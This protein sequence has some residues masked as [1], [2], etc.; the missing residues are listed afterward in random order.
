MVADVKRLGEIHLGIAKEIEFWFE[1]RIPFKWDEAGNEIAWRRPNK[2][3]V[4]TAVRF[5]ADN[6]I[7]AQIDVDEDI[8]ETMLRLEEKAKRRAKTVL[9]GQYTPKRELEYAH[10]VIDVPTNSY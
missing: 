9:K 8:R 1:G 3:E 5:V 4:D 10:E 2:G 6:N 7:S